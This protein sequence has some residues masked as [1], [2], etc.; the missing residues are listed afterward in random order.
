MEYT[1]IKT[2]KQYKEYC[3]KL[4]ELAS[5]KTTKK[6]Q[7]EIEL[8]ELLIEKW[9]NEHSKSK[10]MDPIELLKYMMENKNMSQTDL[11]PILGIHKSAIS[12][13]LSYKKGLSKEVI[14]KLAEFFKVSQ[15]GF[16][17]SYPLVSEI[18]RGHVNEKLMNTKKEFVKA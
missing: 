7:D 17:R 6:I 3:A 8:I 2:A 12:Q 10:D 14:R 18:N 11:I 9:D 1:I 5:K 4:M 16:N 13:I 15:E